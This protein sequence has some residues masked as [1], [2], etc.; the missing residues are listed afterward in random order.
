[1]LD[2]AE[3]VRDLLEQRARP[4][5]LHTALS[6]E[7][8]AWRYAAVPGMDYRAIAV[9][10]A[11]RLVGLGLGRVRARATLTELTLGNVIVA[12]GDR[13]AARAVLRAARRSGVDHVALHAPQGSEVEQVARSSGY[14]A[15][16]GRGIRLVANP[17]PGCPMAL[18][19]PH[20]W[21]LS[22][23]DLEVF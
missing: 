13:S 7:Y 5:R 16:P 9:R 2:A 22:L 18:L 3:P 20:E 23:G 14:L 6:Q 15:A 4:S 10:R 21:G 12:A 17:R 19:D 11:G 1:V 8:L